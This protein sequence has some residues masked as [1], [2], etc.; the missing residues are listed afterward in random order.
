VADHRSGNRHTGE[1]ESMSQATPPHAPSIGGHAP[2][3]HDPSI[4]PN[5]PGATRAP[6]SGLVRYG[7]LEV[8]QNDFASGDAEI[9]LLEIGR[10]LHVLGLGRTSLAVSTVLLMTTSS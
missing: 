6:A 2:A 5:H 3:G 7:K 1:R 4:H 9:V 8:G 10:V